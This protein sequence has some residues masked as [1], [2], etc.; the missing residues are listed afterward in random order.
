MVATHTYRIFVGGV[1]QNARRRIHQVKNGAKVDRKAFLPL[2]DEDLA[3]HVAA[4]NRHLVDV[5]VSVCFVAGFDTQCFFANV[6]HWFFESCAATAG[7]HDRRGSALAT[8]AAHHVDGI[9]FVQVEVGIVNV[10]HCAGLNEGNRDIFGTADI[11]AHIVEFVVELELE[12]QVLFG[13]TVVVDM[14][15]VQRVRIH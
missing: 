8:V 3:R 2:T 11:Q 9:G 7:L 10:R 14:D 6:V 15:F 5:L 13:I 1:Q 4:G 12:G